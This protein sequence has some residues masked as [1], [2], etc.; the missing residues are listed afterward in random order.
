MSNIE[1]PSKEKGETIRLC[2]SVRLHFYSKFA[3]FS[4]HSYRIENT[5]YDDKH[6]KGVIVLNLVLNAKFDFNV[7]IFLTKRPVDVRQV[8]KEIKTVQISVLNENIQK[9]FNF[10]FIGFIREFEQNNNDI[11]IPAVISVMIKKYIKVGPAV[12]YCRGFVPHE[13]DLRY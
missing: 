6:D 1:P 7:W 9:A 2:C 13:A 5:P 12:F 4:L 8:F 11:N 3:R 10:L